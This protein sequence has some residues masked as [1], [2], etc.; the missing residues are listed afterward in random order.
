MAVKTKK[1]ATLLNVLNN[2]PCGGSQQVRGWIQKGS[3]KVRSVV[4]RGRYE[5]WETKVV[6]NANH[7]VS[8]KDSII[9]TLA[10][11]DPVSLP[12]NVFMD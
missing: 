10:G 12:A 9:I 11:K 5:Y 1:E 2:A 6:K 4:M 7:M 8:E 3:V